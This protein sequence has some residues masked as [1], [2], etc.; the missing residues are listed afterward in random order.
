MAPPSKQ[1]GFH[2]VEQP[3]IDKD[4]ALYTLIKQLEYDLA[5]VQNRLELAESRIEVLE[6]DIMKLKKQKYED[7]RESKRKGKAND[8]ILLGANHKMLYAAA[9]G[10]GVPKKPHGCGDSSHCALMQHRRS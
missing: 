2:R 3:A 6:E 1:L 7:G 10:E 9:L 5:D 4:G 8:S